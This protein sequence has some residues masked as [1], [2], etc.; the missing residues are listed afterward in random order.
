MDDQF[1]YVYMSKKRYSMDVFWASENNKE[2]FNFEAVAQ[3]TDNVRDGNKQNG[4]MI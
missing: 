1:T 2:R 3:N 4:T